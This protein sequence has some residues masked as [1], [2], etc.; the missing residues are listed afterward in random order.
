MEI[1][2]KPFGSLRRR[3]PLLLAALAPLFL[4]VCAD[5]GPGVTETRTTE[6]MIQDVLANKED[7]TILITDS[8]MGGLSV[9]ADLS[10]RLPESGVFRNARVVFY[11]AQFAGTGYNGLDSEEEKALIF[12]EVLDAMMEQYD[13]DM[14]LIACN[15]LSVVYEN[16]EFAKNPPIP[17]VGIVDTGVD[18][19]AD[20]F[21]KTP[22]ATAIVFGTLTTIE[23]GVHKDLLVSQGFPEDRIV[24]QAAHRLAGAIERGP[25]SEETMTYIRQ[26][27]GEALEKVGEPEGPIF[28]SFNCTHFG[29]ARDQFATA[30]AEAGYP[31]VELLDPN[32]MM[33]DFLFQPPYLYRHPQTNMTVE[34]VSKLEFTEQERGAIGPLLRAVSP[35]A[36]DALDNYTFDPELF[37]TSFQPPVRD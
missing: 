33:S 11:N 22:D 15:T 34:V 27:V 9:A 7:V 1:P 37:Q 28:G 5:A 32:P 16:T 2:M 35:A 24:G 31:E 6:A 21:Q 25:D 26:F 17:V 23:S 3:A 13:P 18:L 19:I 8:G 29:F 12:G 4:A 10:A 36:A 20:Q 14:I 30:F